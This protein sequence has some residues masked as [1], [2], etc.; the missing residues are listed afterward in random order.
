[1]T[2]QKEASA[3]VDMV[4]FHNGRIFMDEAVPHQR[5]GYTDPL[6]GVSINYPDLPLF[7]ANGEKD[8][9]ET[10]NGNYIQRPWGHIIDYAK[11]RILSLHPE[12]H[13]AVIEA[14]RKDPA[15]VT[16]KKPEGYTSKRTGIIIEY[17]P[18]VEENLQYQDSL[19]TMQASRLHLQL[20]NQREEYIWQ[21]ALVLLGIDGSEK[22]RVTKLQ[23]F[24]MSHPAKFMG[25]FKEGSAEITLKPEL[26][27]EAIVRLAVRHN[28]LSNKNG[29][30]FI[31]DTE[32]SADAAA[33]H[34]EFPD[35]IGAIKLELDRVLKI[36]S[37]KKT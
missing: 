14:I 9:I 2:K 31:G 20:F 7:K 16:S 6:T 24:V 36:G 8:M 1:M 11:R 4:Q 13:K 29:I 17:E 28:V 37:K 12:I 15:S 23:E 32:L 34:K 30:W 22:Q 25:I 33:I 10:A 35:K 19:R 21:Y 26:I 27:N 5:R 18:G 3:K